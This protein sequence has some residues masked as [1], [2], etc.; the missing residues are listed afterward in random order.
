MQKSKVGKL[1]LLKLK[2]CLQDANQDF[3]NGQ[4]KGP[5]GAVVRRLCSNMLDFVAALDDENMKKCQIPKA[6]EILGVR[7]AFPTSVALGHLLTA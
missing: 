2:V 1:A 7:G 6:A 3:K 5:A 4:G